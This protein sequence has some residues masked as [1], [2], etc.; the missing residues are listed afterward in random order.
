MKN[1]RLY[2][3]DRQLKWVGFE[4]VDL[5]LWKK[6]KKIGKILRGSENRTGIF[7]FYKSLIINIL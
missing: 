7:L 2:Q 4:K 6:K 5:F 1:G 3:N